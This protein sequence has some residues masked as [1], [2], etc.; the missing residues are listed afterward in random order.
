MEQKNI[1]NK[2]QQNIDKFNSD[3]CKTIVKDENSLTGLGIK[4]PCENYEELGLL[5][6]NLILSIKYLSQSCRENRGFGNEEVF[7]VIMSLTSLLEATN[8]GVELEGLDKLI[9]KTN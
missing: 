1:D 4:I 8:M 9:I 5:R 3:F 7:A 2:A 6:E